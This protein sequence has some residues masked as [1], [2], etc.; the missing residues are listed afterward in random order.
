MPP[1]LDD[2]KEFVYNTEMRKY[3]L[4]TFCDSKQIER[5]DHRSAIKIRDILTH[6]RF[7]RPDDPWDPDPTRATNFEILDS[8]M[9]RLF[10]GRLEDALNF[11]GT[12][13]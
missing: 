12:S 13:K 5:Y 4:K 8:Q 6:P 1:F 3:T 7:E 9:E 2:A 11:L 10:T